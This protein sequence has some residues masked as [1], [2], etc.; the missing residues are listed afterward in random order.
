MARTR[1]IKNFAQVLLTKR[2]WWIHLA[3]VIGISVVGLVAL[4]SYT[5]LG[6]PPLVDYVSSSSGK[7]VIPADQITRGKVIFHGRGLMSWG[8]FW[9]DGAERG[10]DFTADALHRTVVAMR[11]F[12]EDEIAAQ[13]PLTQ[14]DRDAIVVR[15]QREIHQNGYSEKEGIIQLNDAQV[16][17]WAQ[18]QEHYIRVFTDPNYP[19]KFG[20]DQYITDPG[21]IESLSAFFYWGG[22]VCGANRPGETYSYTHNWPYDPEAA[23]APTRSSGASTVL[24][25]PPRCSRCLPIRSRISS[26]KASAVAI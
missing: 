13:R 18:L 1:K 22:W 6:A 20:R 5:Y 17:A 16:F 9:G 21:E 23:N 19:E 14:A 2:Y 8:S 15:V 10:P 3:I 26:S 12:Y 25:P 24:H 7:V 4:C 11:T